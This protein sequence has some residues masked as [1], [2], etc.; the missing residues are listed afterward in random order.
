MNLFKIREQLNQG[1]P[2]SNLNLKVTFYS[3]ISTNHENQKTS[4]INQEDYFKS[5]IQSNKNWTY[6]EGYIDKGISGISDIKRTNFLNM[7]K[8]SKKNKFDLIITKEISRFSRNT[9]DSIK[10]T[11]E[12]LNNGVAVLFTNDNI[13]TI[14]PDSELRLTIMASLAQDEIR[15]LSERVK[16]GVNMSIKKGHILGNKLYGYK[17]N[18]NKLTIIKK[19]AEV[20]KEI[21]YQYAIQNKSIPSICEYLNNK[22]IKTNYNKKWCTSTILRM[23]KNPKY[24]GYYCANKTSTIDYMTK[25]VINIPK[26]EWILYKSS[27]QI[28]PIIDENTWYKANNKLN[29]KHYTKTTPSKL[30]ILCKKHNTSLYR[31]K[32]L[33]ASNDIS[34]ICS[35]NL[36]S[37]EDKCYINI[38]SNEI[39][40]ILDNLFSNLNI[41]LN[42]IAY[43]LYKR[44]INIPKLDLTNLIIKNVLITY[45]LLTYTYT[46]EIILNINPNLINKKYNKYFSF[47]RGYN[48]KGT[49][50]YIVNYHVVI[51]EN[52]I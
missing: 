46:L 26:E 42:K 24:K 7:I 21:F 32:Q 45:N 18:K 14:Y 23:I 1:I 20:V 33:K 9:L 39:N 34:Y 11:R 12:L 2:L 3:R 28:P 41:N 8:D 17:K 13:N 30:N 48:T 36:L 52:K 16:F 51:L 44:K 5:L 15:R 43:N 37:K 6:I 4:L 47:K 25:K 22:N 40:T 35:H 31:R 27:N 50:R 10:Y 29:K 49:K 19:E 38:R